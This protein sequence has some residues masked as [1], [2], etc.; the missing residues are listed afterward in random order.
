MYLLF[1]VKSKI[2]AEMLED[3]NG[4][5]EFNLSSGQIVA[6]ICV[7][8]TSWLQFMKTLEEN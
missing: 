7:F 6:N 4:S 2:S 1:K 8:I 3:T 5:S